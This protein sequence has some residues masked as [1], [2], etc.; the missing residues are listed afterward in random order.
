MI[1]ER[2]KQEETQKQKQRRRSLILIEN[3]RPRSRA[4]LLPPPPPPSSPSR[5]GTLAKTLLR[6]KSVPFGK[7]PA[8]SLSPARCR[9]AR[10]VLLS[11]NISTIARDI[12]LEGYNDFLLRSDVPF[13]SRE[14]CP[15]NAIAEI[16]SR[17]NTK[18]LCIEFVALRGYS[19]DVREKRAE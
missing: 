6:F 1:G 9:R 2:G 18:P 3:T 10:T 5:F 13:L 12:F 16:A 14:T 17:I 8:R 7:V 15:P 4:L 19:A 11:R